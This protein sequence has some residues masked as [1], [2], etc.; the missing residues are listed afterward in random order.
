MPHRTCILVCTVPLLTSLL[1]AKSAA[2][3][4]EIVVPIVAGVYV[5]PA[6]VLQTV[7]VGDPGDL[8]DNL[9]RGVPTSRVNG[10]AASKT[11]LRRVSLARLVRDVQA[12]IEAGT[13]IP[14]DARYLAGIQQI[15]YLFVYPDEHDVVIAGPAEGWEMDTSGRVVGQ[16][17]RQPVVRLDDLVVALRVLTT[18][19]RGNPVIGCSID[20]TDE[21]MR[22]F[23]QQVARV[24][25]LDRRQ[26]D[27]SLLQG[28]RDS[29][30]MQNITIWGVPPDSRLATVLVEADYRMKLIGIGLEDPR[31]RNL[32]TYYALL[33]PGSIGPQKLQRWWFVPEYEAIT[34]TE[35]GDAFELL[36]PR[37]K[38]IGA[39]DKLMPTG[40]AVRGGPTSGLTTRF[41]QSFSA[42]FE[43]L[44]RINAAYAELQ[45]AFD[46]VVIAALIDTHDMINQ[47]APDLRYLLQAD[48]YEPE[49]YP[50]PK[51]VESVVN[52]KWVGNKLAIGV[53][54][55]VIIDGKKLVATAAGKKPPSPKLSDRRQ[56]GRLADTT[57]R[58]WSD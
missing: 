36:G 11:E 53:G 17:T 55:G 18:R 45:N 33:G 27:A 30:G 21:G 49:K 23:N 58:W 50:A 43:D 46:L 57:G 31:V 38:L 22:R 3:Q 41:A 9:R 5:D 19:G 6:G 10:A 13:P 2:Q 37:A 47:V 52:S 44:A 54:G 14:D 7:R 15:Q 56:R 8:L 12:H 39:D 42:H 40:Q 1:A 34:A 4:A 35:A 29:V 20:Q 28:V 24:S 25:T 48:G 32:T 51:Q 26:I 16:R